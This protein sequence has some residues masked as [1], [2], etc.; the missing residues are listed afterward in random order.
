MADNS[1]NTYA[2]GGDPVIAPSGNSFLDSFSNL[3]NVLTSTAAKGYALYDSIAEREA[4][5]KINA[6]NAA[7]P[8]QQATPSYQVYSPADFFSNPELVQKAVLTAGTLSLVLAGAFYLWKK[9]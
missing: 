4:L 8:P 1:Q 2:G 5:R 3:A 6:R 9:A 7:N